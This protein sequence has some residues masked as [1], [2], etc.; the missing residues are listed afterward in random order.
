[1]YF[2]SWLLSLSVTILRFI[3]VDADIKFVLFLSSITTGLSIYLLMDRWIISISQQIQ[4][5]MPVQV[6]VITC[7]FPPLG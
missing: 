3:Y 4:I 7:A 5:R 2:T 6:F 1:M